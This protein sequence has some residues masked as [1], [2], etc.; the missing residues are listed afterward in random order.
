MMNLNMMPVAL[1]IKSPTSLH[2][3]SRSG[4]SAALIISPLPDRHRIGAACAAS[5]TTS[6]ILTRLNALRLHPHHSLPVRPQV[7]G[8]KIRD[9]LTSQPSPPPSELDVRPHVRATISIRQVRKKGR[10]A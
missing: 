4:L 9:A 3:T 1:S 2:R 10:R 7:L 6:S 8:L 5:T